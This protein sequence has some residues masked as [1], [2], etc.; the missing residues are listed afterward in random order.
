MKNLIDN[1]NVI[2]DNKK[3]VNDVS[4]GDIIKSDVFENLLYKD[5]FEQNPT[6]GFYVNP[7]IEFKSWNNI[8][9][10]M[11]ETDGRIKKANCPP[12][13]ANQYIDYKQKIDPE[14]EF[15]VIMKFLNA[16]LRKEQHSEDNL[17]GTFPTTII[18]KMLD[19]DGNFDEYGIEITFNMNTT[20]AKHAVNTV[21]LVGV[22]KI[23]YNRIR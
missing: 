9:G 11:I 14:S 19:P 20:N 22:M 1:K 13:S 23:Q 10:R 3:F 12:R 7:Y 5:M 18:A 17:S 21:E 4:I 8:A 2:I 16:E 15:V 6:S